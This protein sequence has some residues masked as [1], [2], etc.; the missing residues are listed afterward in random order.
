MFLRVSPLTK[1]N[2]VPLLGD[3][4]KALRD[5]Y[6][7]IAWDYKQ[8][9][10]QLT[11]D[12]K[13]RMI[14]WY[15]RIHKS[16]NVESLTEW[17]IADLLQRSS[18]GSSVLSRYYFRLQPSDRDNFIQYYNEPV[19][20]D[21]FKDWLNKKGYKLLKPVN[22]L[23]VN[24]LRDCVNGKFDDDCSS[25]LYSDDARNLAAYFRSSL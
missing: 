18:R 21:E 19:N 16:C 20:E 5:E 22:N 17:Q 24:M 23:E 1:A 11:N 9:D 12:I 4:D 8:V 10:Y 13:Q 3:N 6:I 15:K 25:Y 2:D 14:D 7:Q